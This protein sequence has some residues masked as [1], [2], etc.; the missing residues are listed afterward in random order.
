M[1]GTTLDI[2]VSGTQISNLIYGDDNV[3]ITDNFEDQQLIL[4]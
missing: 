3:I 4:H 2:R 1:E